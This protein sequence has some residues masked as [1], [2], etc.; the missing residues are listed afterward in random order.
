MD[1]LKINDEIAEF[2][3]AFNSLPEIVEPP[4]TTLE[5]LR[6]RTREKYWNRLLRYFLDPSAP[7]GLGSGLLQEFLELVEEETGAVD[8]TDSD[9]ETV[10]VESEISSDNGR[11]DLLL[12][13]EGEWFVCI[14]LKVTAPETGSQT[15]G[16]ANSRRLGDV[17]VTDYRE[18][19]R[20]YVYLAKQMHDPPASE[21][22]TRLYWSDVQHSIGQVIADARGQ[23]PA[24]TTAQLADFRDTVRKVTMSEQ[25]YDRQQDEYVELYLEHTD[26]IDAVQ[27]AFERMVDSQIEEWATRFQEQHQPDNWDDTWNCAN[28]KYGKI[29]KDTW[30]RDENGKP[31]ASWSEATFRLEFRHQIRKEQS[32]K[33]GNVVFRTVIPKNSDGEYRNRCQE[34]FN[35]HFDKIDAKTKSTKIATMGNRRILTEATYSYDPTKGPEGYYNTLSKAFD[36]HV[37][38]VPLLT[39]IYESA[40]ADFVS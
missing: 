16:Y 27:T 19:E 10:R 24:R 5:I 40:F 29:Y 6:G 18:Q 20:H 4:S 25:S 13:L 21:E 31:V 15:M 8:L 1:S 22:F 14:E 17:S 7:H 33:E 12:Y 3:S 23:Y 35:A 32:W 11:P 37:I 30:R 28:G 9:L 26:A 38:L 34:V 36:D 2:A 39:E